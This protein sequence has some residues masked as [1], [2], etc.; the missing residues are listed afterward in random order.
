MKRRL[1]NLA[2]FVSRLLCVATVVLWVV[3]YWWAMTL[4]RSAGPTMYLTDY[5]ISVEQGRFR[6]FVGHRAG[7]QRIEG[8]AWRLNTQPAE[9]SNDL[10]PVLR[11]HY[12]ST[13]EHWGI[14][15]IGVEFHHNHSSSYSYYSFFGYNDVLALL[16]AILPIA[17]GW[18]A[19]RHQKQHQRGLCSSCGYDMRATPERCPECGTVRKLHRDRRKTRRC[20][21]PTWHQWAW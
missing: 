14:A 13:A 17:W 9:K 1:F 3:S 7:G 2:T 12:A 19:H 6:F 15:V 5:V 11:F 10:P 4:S 8:V 21:G 16:F 20:S 18:K